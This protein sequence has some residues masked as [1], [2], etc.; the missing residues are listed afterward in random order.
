MCL[1]GNAFFFFFNT[2]AFLVQTYF[3][4]IEL[5]VLAC[6][7]CQ[8]WKVQEAGK[9]Q[10]SLAQGPGTRTE[11]NGVYYQGSVAEKAEAPVEAQSQ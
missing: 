3:Q 4:K 7:A 1:W 5:V 8:C 6:L 11:E 10:H 2:L 9:R